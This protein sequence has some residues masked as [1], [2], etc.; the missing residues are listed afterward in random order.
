[1]MKQTEVPIT[2]DSISTVDDQTL[3]TFLHLKKDNFSTLKQITSVLNVTPATLFLPQTLKSLDDEIL[4]NK[5]LIIDSINYLDM[6]RLM[7]FS[8]YRDPNVFVNVLLS[9]IVESR[10]VSTSSHCLAE[11]AVDDFLY[12]EKEDLYNFVY[13][14]KVILAIYIYSIVSVIFTT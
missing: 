9:N 6:V 5:N 14:N 8:I 13:D 11:N 7:S 2:F 12:S 3:L 4:I 10:T 1:M